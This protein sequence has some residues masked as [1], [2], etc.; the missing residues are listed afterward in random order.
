MIAYF[1]AYSEGEVRFH[2]THTL[3]HIYTNL[4]KDCLSRAMDSPQTRLYPPPLDFFLPDTCFT[5]QSMIPLHS[6][7]HSSSDPPNQRYHFS[8]SL[9][10]A[11]LARNAT[12]SMT[13]S[14][15]TR[16]AKFTSSR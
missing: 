16:H 5:S 1:W 11:M 13:S 14:G 10:S 3:H 2:I 7:H 12:G 8:L 9:P 6:G 4:L 15:T